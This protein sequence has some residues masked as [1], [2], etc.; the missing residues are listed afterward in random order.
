MTLETPTAGTHA[1]FCLH[2]IAVSVTA[3]DPAPVAA[4]A[5]R[6]ADFAERTRHGAE[7]PDANAITV[8]FGPPG[9]SG[10]EAP[11][12]G[13]PVYDTPHGSLFY[14]PEDDVLSGRFGEVELVCAASLGQLR[15]GAPGYSGQSLY[16]ATHPLLTVSLMEVLERRGLYSLHAACVAGPTG[17]AV[18]IAGPSG[19]GKSTLTLALAGAGLKVLSDDIVFLEPGPDRVRVRGFADTLAFTE[20]TLRMF[21][22]LAGRVA[23]APEAGFPKRL[24]R[25]EELFHRGSLPDADPVALVFPHVAADRPSA[26]AQLPS[27]DALLRL[28][29]DVLLT[30]PTTTQAHLAA[31]GA[32]LE[33]V[34]CHELRSGCDIDRA[35]ALVRELM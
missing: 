23:A 31:V 14:A 35:V 7:A 9:A 26:I 32:L 4:V 34:S 8:V 11:E 24:A 18:L 21:P 28:V 29:P 20:G 27:G 17:R 13:R 30:E 2:G 22:E 16:L 12:D 15:L 25:V 19:A 1:R 5:R 33:R 6:L 3:A 10:G